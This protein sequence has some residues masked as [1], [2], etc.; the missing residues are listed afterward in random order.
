MVLAIINIYTIKIFKS[1]KLDLNTI[2]VLLTLINF[3]PYLTRFYIA[4]PTIINDLIF[5]AGILILLQV[6]L[7]RR[8]LSIPILIGYIFIFASRQT[9]IGLILAYLTTILIKGKK[10]ISVKNEIVGLIIFI[11]FLILNFYY[12]SNTIENSSSRYEL[13]SPQMR[14][15]GL[16]IQ[17][18]PVN[19]KIIFLL[20]PLLSF[21]PLI[22]YFILFNFGDCVSKFI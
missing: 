19:E 8:L 20:L 5:I 18:F 17:D 16:F 6:L 3:N 10:L 4:V 14:I 11:L 1:L 15:F 22:F 12:S 7:S 13:Y 9:S 2:L 21:S